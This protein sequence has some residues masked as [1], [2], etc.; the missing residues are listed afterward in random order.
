MKGRLPLWLG[1]W[2]SNVLMAWVGSEYCRDSGI[3][4]LALFPKT[5]SIASITLDLPLPLGP[6]TD[7]KHCTR[8]DNGQKHC[9]PLHPNLSCSKP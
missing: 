7:E 9:I 1:L 6:T 5:N 3:T 4:C 2:P 8:N